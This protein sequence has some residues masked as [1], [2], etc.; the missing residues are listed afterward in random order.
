MSTEKRSDARRRGSDYPVD[1]IC[2]IQPL[3]D[4]MIKRVGLSVAGFAL[5]LALVVS[6]ASA[7]FRAGLTN[8]ATMVTGR[9]PFANL[10]QGSARSVLGVTGASTADVASIASS[11]DGDVLRRASGAVGFGTI[12]AASIS[13]LGSA[14][15]AFTN[16][17]GA[18][19]Q[20]TNDASYATL[21]AVAGVGYLTS[22]TAH[23]VLSATHGD[24]LAD[25]LVRGDV[26]Y[27][28]STPKLARLAK[29][30]VLSN[31]SHDGVDVSWVTATGTGAPMRGT[32]P[33]VTTSLL[34]GNG[35]GFLDVAADTTGLSRGTNAQKLQIYETRDAGLSNYSRLS[36]SAPALGP[37]TFASEAAGSGTARAIT[38]LGGNVGI[39]TSPVNYNLHVGKASGD[40]I[41]AIQSYT[42]GVGAFNYLINDTG[43]VVAF[44]GAYGSANSLFPSAGAF[45]SQNNIY[46]FADSGVSSGG[47]HSISLLTG[48]YTPS[49]QTRLFIGSTGLVGIGTTSPSGQLAVTQTVT[50]TGV[51]KGFVY[52][53][54]VNTN[55]TLSTEIPAVTL[56]TAGRQWATGALT[57]QREVLITAPTYSFV[58]AST[59]TNAATLAIVDAPAAG[60]N[61]TLTNSYALWVQ[62][63]KAKFDG[64][65]YA[66]GYQS[67]DGTAGVTVTTCTGFKNG[68]CISGT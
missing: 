4:S 60:T 63:G 17:S 50:A 53:G 51:L 16:K 40:V 31:L 41:S 47:T 5:A 38:F 32:S 44:L 27:V 24:T 10:T 26:L 9:L 33:T 61:A 11:S 6:P 29:P 67:S 56:T 3:G 52:T 25:T 36:I 58:G 62:A 55:Q 68:L 14:T 15:V 64:G 54:A 45:G 1:R 12:P 49:T 23:N 43:N 37:I 2:L 48:G 18:I 20:W 22:V 13:D 66:S 21:A 46:V 57:T 28:N 35:Q 8:L 65:V 34:F 19:S 42:S 59:I 30:S 39:G 7:Q